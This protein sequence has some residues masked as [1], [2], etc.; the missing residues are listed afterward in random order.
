M[1]DGGPQVRLRSGS[2]RPYDGAISAARTCYSDR[3]VDP[4]EITERQRSSI[5]PLTFEGGHHTVFQ[6]ATFEFALS[7]IS[8]QLVWSF[9]HGFP[10]Y[11][12]EQ[13]SQRYVRLDHVAAV[14]PP[15]L[16]GAARARYET[17]VDQGRR[18]AGRHRGLGP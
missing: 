10:F 6:H 11:N 1:I 5:G 7:G 18:R 15:E 9:L 3:V 13:Q 8:R 2:D 16:A 12:T 4:D 17:A 14:V